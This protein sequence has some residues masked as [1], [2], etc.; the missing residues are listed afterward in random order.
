MI[1]A[2]RERKNSCTMSPLSLDLHDICH[3]NQQNVRRIQ[4]TTDKNHIAGIIK[5]K[6]N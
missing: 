1:L 6:A 5:N 3:V 2:N 4:Y